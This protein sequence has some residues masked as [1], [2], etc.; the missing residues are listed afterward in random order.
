MSVDPT[1]H[2]GGSSS[3]HG[4]YEYDEEEKTTGN[5]CDG[6]SSDH[7]EEDHRLHNVKSTTHV[8]ADHHRT[9]E[10]EA[11]GD[12]EI[13]DTRATNATDNENILDQEH[14]HGDLLITDDGFYTYDDDQGGWTQDG[15]LVELETNAEG[16]IVVAPDDGSDR[17][18]H[19]T[20]FNSKEENQDLLD[21]EYQDNDLLVTDE[22][23]FIYS[24]DEESWT[25]DGNAVELEVND[26]GKIVTTGDSDQ[27]EIDNEDNDE[28]NNPDFETVSDGKID[29]FEQGTIG[30]CW[31]LSGILAVT[32]TP[33]G[34]QLIKDTITDNGDG[35]YSVKFAGDPS[36]KTYTVTADDLNNSNSAGDIDVAILEEAARQYYEENDDRDINDGG[37]KEFI[38]LLTGLDVNK[39]YASSNPSETKEMIIDQGKK[40]DGYEDGNII[41]M[42]AS[43]T[44]MTSDGQIHDIGDNG[45]GH[46]LAITDIDE[47]ANTISYVNPWDS[48]EVITQDLDEFAEQQSEVTW[49]NDYPS[50]VYATP[51][52]LEVHPDIQELSHDMDT[53]TAE[54]IIASLDLDQDTDGNTTDLALYNV[55]H[56]IGGEYTDEERAAAYLLLEARKQ[57]GTSY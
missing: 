55:M 53:G 41:M 30:D 34:K 33:E 40:H 57:E 27:N 56:N 5:G 7:H 13:H 44:W 15:Q 25:S 2:S 32:D 36:G 49:G 52:D 23:A 26:D 37:N 54:S 3:V 48:T 4:D 12:I 50:I 47:D 6:C 28:E 14:S 29:H 31:V 24:E 38:E 22:G 46:M 18:I 20:R 17:A 21:D 8:M 42:F 11:A 39:G 10:E 16:E 43:D 35:T 51:G 45:S 1:T 9:S 19:D